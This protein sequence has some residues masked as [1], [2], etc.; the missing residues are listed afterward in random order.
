MDEIDWLPEMLSV[1]PWSGDTY[2]ELYA[3]F[4]RDFVLSQPRYRGF[5]V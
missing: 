2:E 1:N 3:V 4:R 5:H